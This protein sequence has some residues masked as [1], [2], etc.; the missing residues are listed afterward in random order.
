MNPSFRVGRSIHVVIPPRDEEEFR[1][2]LLQRLGVR[3]NDFFVR[4]VAEEATRERFE[5]DKRKRKIE[6]TFRRFDGRRRKKVASISE[7]F[8]YQPLGKIAKL[9]DDLQRNSNDLMKL[10]TIG[11]T[12]EGRKILAVRI[13]HPRKADKRKRVLLDC[14]IHAREWM[15]PLACLFTMQRLISTPKG[16]GF[17]ED[18]WDFVI[19]PVVNPDGYFYSWSKPAARLW[20]KNRRRLPEGEIFS[21][22]NGV[23][24]NRNFPTAFAT[25]PN[26]CGADYPGPNALSEPESAAL[27]GLLQPESGF[28]AY[29]SV[30]A[31]S[32]MVLVPYA[33]KPGAHEHETRYKPVLNAISEAMNSIRNVSMPYE[34]FYEFGSPPELLYAVNG[35]SLDYAYVAGSVEFSLLYELSPSEKA[36]AKFA[37]PFHLPIEQIEPTLRE[38]WSGLQAGIKRMLL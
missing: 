37:N 5:I 21:H 25:F 8:I 15:S 24:L 29:V 1:E 12:I 33:H 14:G 28:L 13:S 10:Y 9:I 3:E 23:D 16:R 4:S 17:I 7:F 2:F 36:S 6:L 38:F 27:A 11:D 26:N 22:C 20:R 18:G 32:R 30:H 35:S 31:Y 34:E 19:V